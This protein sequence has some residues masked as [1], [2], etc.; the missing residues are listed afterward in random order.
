MQGAHNKNQT[1]TSGSQEVLLDTRLLNSFSF[2]PRLTNLAKNHDIKITPSDGNP[3]IFDK[4]VYVSN[5]L[6]T[7][8]LRMQLLDL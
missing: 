2:F 6:I 3:V 5:S 8:L 4:A 7:F 1:K